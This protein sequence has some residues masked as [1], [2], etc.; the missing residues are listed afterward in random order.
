MNGYFPRQQQRYPHEQQQYGVSNPQQQHQPAANNGARGS[1]MDLTG[2]MLSIPGAQSLDDIVQNAKEFR[3]RSMPIAYQNPNTNPTPHDLDDSM[4]RTSMVDMMDFGG[5][6]PDMA[7]FNFDTSGFDAQM[8]DMS[9]HGSGQGNRGG[10]NNPLSVNTRFTGHGA[11]G[12][13]G[14][15]QQSGGA[16]FDSALSGQNAFET[17]LQ[18]PYLTSAFPPSASLG[19]GMNAMSTDMPSNNM[20]SAE[21]FNSSMANSPIQ[22]AYSTSMLGPTM[23]DPGGGGSASARSSRTPNT[24]ASGT[25][26]HLVRQ[27]NPRTNSHETDT[28]SAARTPNRPDS[29]SQTNSAEFGSSKMVSRD[30]SNGPQMVNGRA[31]S[32][33]A[34]KGG[35]PSSMAGRT[36][37]NTQFKDAY[38]PSGYDLMSILVSIP[39]PSIYIQNVNS[40]HNFLS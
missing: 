3:R 12:F 4:R 16:G 34:P 29:L 31:L 33:S 36:H 19:D 13:G 6:S 1:M 5:G 11:D 7:N 27:S 38:A 32:W 18:S 8:L 14:M 35:W 40:N 37:M 26:S 15:G 25:P 17:D 22:N 21:H 30:D 23:Q 39:N 20:F 2:G 9:G 28:H 24:N 10:G